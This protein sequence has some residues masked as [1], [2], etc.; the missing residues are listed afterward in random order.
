MK[1]ND[2][3]QHVEEPVHSKLY[4]ALAK[5]QSEIEPPVMDCKGQFNNSYASLHSIY[6][7]CR[8]PLA[9]HGITMPEEVGTDDKGAYW[10][11]TSLCHTSGECKKFRM[12]I[13]VD[14]Q[15]GCHGFVSGLTYARRA[16]ITSILSLPQEEDDD[17]A[18][19]MN[20]TISQA[21]TKLINKELTGFP[22][23]LQAVLNGYGI[24][25]ISDLPI[26]DY[27]PALRVIKKRK[28]EIK[29]ETSKA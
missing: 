15:G 13:I 4:E 29:N 28:E 12:P 2:G 7:A 20:K 11:I 16:A 22:D 17:G 14:K 25:K 3:N 21:Q 18:R 23:L 24:T 8:I 26:H 1:E 27:H 19:A 6:N 9:K 5:A 10:L